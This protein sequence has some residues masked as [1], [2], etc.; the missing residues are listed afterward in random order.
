MSLCSDASIVRVTLWRK[1]V[2]R[3]THGKLREDASTVRKFPRASSRIRGRVEL[4]RSKAR[5]KIKLAD[6]SEVHMCIILDQRPHE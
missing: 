6:H 1:S 5:I 2:Q 3:S 4:E